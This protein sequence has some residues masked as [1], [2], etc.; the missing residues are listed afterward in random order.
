VV[1]CTRRRVLT[2]S[3]GLAAAFG[4]ATTAYWPLASPTTT[5]QAQQAAP[6]S[7]VTIEAF[8]FKPKDLDIKAEAKVAWT[9]DDDVTHTV[10]S[11]TP[12]RRTEMFNASLNGKGARFDFTFTKTG[13]YHYFCN[14]HQQMRGAIT[15]K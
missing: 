4:I 13:T 5:A 12:D 6:G 1:S 14:R 11:G 10:T 9:N 8:Q 15:V 3:A 7:A 2:V